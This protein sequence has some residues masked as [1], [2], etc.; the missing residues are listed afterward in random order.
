MELK[1]TKFDIR[2]T[3]RE[4]RALMDCSEILD[5]PASSIIRKAVMEYYRNHRHEL[6]EKIGKVG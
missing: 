6:C 1:D 2:L 3:S 4:H 5:I